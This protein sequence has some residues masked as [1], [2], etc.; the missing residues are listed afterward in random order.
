[1]YVDKENTKRDIL[2]RLRDMNVKPH[3]LRNFVYVSFP[4]V[5]FF[6]TAKGGDDL[7]SMADEYQPDVVILD[8]WSRFLQGEEDSSKTVQNAYN[9]SLSKL[10]ARGITV[11]RIDHVGRDA[12]KGSR[13]SSAKNED[14]DH[15]W[16]LVKKSDNHF[17]LERTHTRT[18]VGVDKVDLIRMTDPLC[19]VSTFADDALDVDVQAA[20]ARLD[21]L[22]IPK[23]WGRGK[24]R[25]KLKDFGVSMSDKTLN[26][27][28]R[29]RK[30]VNE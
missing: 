24:V 5:A 26:E 15:V 12:S 9:Y 10:K 23:E 16:M 7:I 22:K 11:L 20:I 27:A 8:S 6:D 13:G 4:S 17:L 25:E 28:I 21:E 19:H 29:A 18:G 30:S 1:M 2:R 3:E 14:V